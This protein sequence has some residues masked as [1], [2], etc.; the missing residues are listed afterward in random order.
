MTETELDARGLVCPLPV[1]RA[2]RA[3]RGLAAG[4][5]LRVLVTD[6]AAPEDFVR[7]CATTGHELVASGEA[8]EAG[9]VAILIRKRG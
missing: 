3:L 6:P 5:R 1:L 4:D 7:F 2:N 8:G 9:V